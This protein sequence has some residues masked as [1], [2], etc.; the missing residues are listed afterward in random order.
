[1]APIT[2]SGLGDMT[3]AHAMEKELILFFDDWV[4]ANL[5]VLKNNYVTRL[6]AYFE[7]REKL[8]KLWQ[9]SKDDVTEMKQ[10]HEL[11]RHS[12]IALSSMNL[13]KKR[14]YA[15]FVIN[16]KKSDTS[17]FASDEPEPVEEVD[18]TK[19]ADSPDG[20]QHLEQQED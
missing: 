11:Y 6:A 10:A 5:F 17:I 9:E 1:M 7:T 12:L 19:P 8:I 3:R 16:K 20:L 18:E 13:I 14:M 15:Y 2:A 4:Y